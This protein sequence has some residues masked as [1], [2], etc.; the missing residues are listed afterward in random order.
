ML[1]RDSDLDHLQDQASGYAEVCFFL[2][3]EG[4]TSEVENELLQRLR[5]GGHNTEVNY[6][7]ATP[8]LQKGE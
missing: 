6:T 4:F 8:C 7:G 3:G 5:A 2:S 1:H